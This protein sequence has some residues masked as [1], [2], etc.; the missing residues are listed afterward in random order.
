[1]PSATASSAQRELP[2]RPC[3]SPLKAMK[4][5]GLYLNRTPV[6]D[7]APLAGMPMEMLNLYETPVKDLSPLK[8]MPIK[9]L[10]LNRTKVSDLSPIAT[11]PLVSLTLHRTKVADIS[12][13]RR[14]ETLERLHIGETPVS[15]LTPLAKLKLSRLIFTPGTIKKGMEDLPRSGREDGAPNAYARFAALVHGRPPSE[16]QDLLDFVDVATG[17]ER[18]PLDEVEPIESVCRRFATAAMSH[19]SLSRE[20]HESMAIAMNRIG[21]R[22]NCGEGGE[23]RAGAL[24]GLPS[25][26]PPSLEFG[27]KPAARL[28]VGK[29][30]GAHR[31]PAAQ[32]PFG[33]HAVAEQHPALRIVL[34]NNAPDPARRTRQRVKGSA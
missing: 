18:V 6:T 4:L 28:A 12:P 22:S 29:A 2:T 11:C 14:V 16:L 8:G 33:L 3:S 26:S 19:G 23:A 13:L 24:K 15:D 7:L 34:E 21:G 9:F 32:A 5:T 1:M 31:R 20:V 27:D 10:W 25:G 30:F 17:R